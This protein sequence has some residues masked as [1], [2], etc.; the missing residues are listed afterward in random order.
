MHKTM[1]RKLVLPIILMTA[2]M[3]LPAVAK[4]MLA[5]TTKVEKV[6][7]FKN[8]LGFF[9][10]S[11]TLPN[12]LTQIELT[13]LP[14]PVVGTFW[15]AGDADV[16]IKNVVSSIAERKETQPIRSIGELLTENAG[17]SLILDVQLPSIPAAGTSQPKT[18]TITGTLLAQ[19][20]PPT[21][22]QPNPYIMETTPAN[23]TREGYPYP[24][25]TGFNSVML[26]T[27]TG[28]RIVRMDTIV[29]IRRADNR[30]LETIAMKTT[31]V[32]HAIVT[33]E[34]PA[35]GKKLYTTSL[36][37]GITWVPSYL[38]DLSD[39]KTA[40]FTAK[41]LIVNEV[42]DLDNVDVELITGYPNIQL[43]NVVSPIAMK[44]SLAD[45]LRSLSTG[46]TENNERD[47][48]MQQMAYNAY[49]GSAGGSAMPNYSA[50]AA[51]AGEATEDLFFYPVKSFSLKKKETALVPLFT[52]QTP[53]R[54][55]YTWKVGDSP[56]IRKAQGYDPYN[57]GMPGMGP[58][59]RDG[60]KPAEEEIWHCC[61]LKN[62]LKGPLTTATTE[63]VSQGRFVG[64]DICLY[65][66]AGAETT[67]R[68]NRAM[69]VPAEQLEY[70]LDRKRNAA[71]FYGRSYDWIRLCGQLQLTNR[72]A[73]AITVEITKEVA[74]EVTEMIPEGKKDKLAKRIK[75]VNPSTTMTWTI[76]LKPGEE[77]TI[78]YIYE[79]YINN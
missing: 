13:G 17:Q 55:I 48:M 3:T 14:V 20:E 71:Q 76:E 41:A 8:G 28:I 21:P 1:T 44:Q 54:H 19:P 11:M 52:V 77:K 75:E 23:P 46:R 67:I 10:S 64:Q 36:A 61:R 4:S 39:P 60:N 66:P 59:G 9:T 24:Y 49:R 74:G 35:A 50:Q 18:E 26:Q 79:T 15:V 42:V 58:G 27:D 30:L 7:L 29:N 31:S 78:K 33:L 65:T 6:A 70:E 57:N 45:F 51:T 38:V 68:I 34:K 32:P 22:I 53:Y 69:N 47:M 2:A 12:G 73:A 56:A 25:P 72:T 63:F 5:P 37:K 40:T 16:K 62:T 43:E